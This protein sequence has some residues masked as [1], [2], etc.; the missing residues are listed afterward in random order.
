MKNAFFIITLSVLQA[1]CA[2]QAQVSGGA[3]ALL[4]FAELANEITVGVEELGNERAVDAPG[5]TPLGT[6]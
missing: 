2:G 4:S 6:P 5:I 3:G 1:A